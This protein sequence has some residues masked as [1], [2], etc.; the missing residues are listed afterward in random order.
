MVYC[1]SCVLSKV[2]SSQLVLSQFHPKSAASPFETQLCFAANHEHISHFD[3]KKKET[4]ARVQSLCFIAF[5]Y[6]KM[7][8]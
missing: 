8:I 3:K 5:F 4:R 6:N 7:Y 2:I 1:G